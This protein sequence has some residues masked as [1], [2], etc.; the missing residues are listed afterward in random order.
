M[1]ENQEN[2]SNFA[3]YQQAL[4]HALPR[5]L[6]VSFL[7][8]LAS[9][10]F[11]RQIAPTYQVHFSYF[12]SISSRQ[13]TP[14]YRY[15]DYYAISA[16]DLFAQTLAAWIKTPETIST[17]YRASGLTPPSDDA[18]KLIRSVEASRQAPQLVSV[19]V[20]ASTAD[21]TQQLAFGLIAVTKDSIERL[22]A[23]SQPALRFNIVASEP[24]LGKKSISTPVIVAAVFIFTLFFSV[25]LV[26]LKA[27][28]KQPSA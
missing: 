21:Q 16:M 24:W 10:A 6:L 3:Y 19:T 2:T 27:S 8:A 28:F 9:Y 12:I 1:A 25:N 4:I 7:F 17:A 11:V 22:Q 18:N 26:I 14:D 23:A 20:R 5:V 13:E 15:D